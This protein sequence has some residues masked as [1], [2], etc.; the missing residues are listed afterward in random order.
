MQITHP[1]D[2]YE[3]EYF[4]HSRWKF[5]TTHLK[6]QHEHVDSIYDPRRIIYLRLL[7]MRV[8]RIKGG[9][10]NLTFQQ[11]KRCFHFRRERLNYS[12]S[13]G[14]RGGGGG[15]RS[16]S[17]MDMEPQNGSWSSGT[18]EVHVTKRRKFE[19]PSQQKSQISRRHECHTR[20]RRN[21]TKTSGYRTRIP[22][23]ETRN[24]HR[25]PPIRAILHT[26]L[27]FHLPGEYCKRF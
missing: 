2:E 5:K 11:V 10:Q 12:Y 27:W 18:P 17:T 7:P 15:G 1:L 16:L 4:E 21:T 24:P 19:F 6:V 26:M 20:K 23:K 8:K 25:I 3:Y 22:I 9:Q 13:S 14:G